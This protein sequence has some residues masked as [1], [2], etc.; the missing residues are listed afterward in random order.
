MPADHAYVRGMSHAQKLQLL[1]DLVDESRAAN[2]RTKATLA[3]FTTWMAAKF[4][5]SRDA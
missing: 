3:R 4:D 1:R 2:E 5:G